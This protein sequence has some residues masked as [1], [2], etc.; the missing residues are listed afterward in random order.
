M[1]SRTPDIGLVCEDKVPETWMQEFQ[2]AVASDQLDLLIERRISTKA[3]AAIEWLM[4]TAAVL[5]VAKSYFDGFLGEMGK[6][7]YAA[8]KAGIKRLCEH[9]AKVKVTLIGTAGKV[10]A[11]QPYSMLF[12]IYFDPNEKGVFKFLVPVD[13]PQE[14]LDIAIDAFLDFLADYYAGTLDPDVER[15]L[16][17]APDL[18][19]TK[20]VA[21][22][23]A[24]GRIDPL[25]ARTR[26]FEG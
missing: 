18:G 1:L 20:L 2:A 11:D 24:T 9:F 10:A 19:R 16:G 15:R 21:F 25:N 6:D 26:R 23:P 7:H 17:E 13:V 14:E 5:F 4:P 3:F 22:N 8:L 12:S